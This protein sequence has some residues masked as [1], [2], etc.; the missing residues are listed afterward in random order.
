MVCAVTYSTQPGSHIS[1]CNFLYEWLCGCVWIAILSHIPIYNCTHV[2]ADILKSSHGAFFHC[3]QISRLVIHQDRLHAA[4]E[5]AMGG[6]RQRLEKITWNGS[7]RRLYVSLYSF[8]V[9]VSSREFL[10]AKKQRV[11]MWDWSD[12]RTPTDKETHCR[13]IKLNNFL[14]LDKSQQTHP[15]PV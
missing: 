9:R 15:E 1:M 13:S 5:G 6:R 2:Q 11:E 3:M 12:W 14:I 7:R 8:N 4:L 10:K